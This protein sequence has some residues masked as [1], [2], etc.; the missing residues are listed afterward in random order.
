MLAVVEHRRIVFLALTDDHK[1]VEVDGAQERA[2]GIDRCAIG[3]QLVPA[4]DVG[5]RANGG[6]LGRAHEFHT[7]VAV[8]VEVNGGCCCAGHERIL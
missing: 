3:G 7:E 1:T 2:H 8:W 4:A 6:S 5:H